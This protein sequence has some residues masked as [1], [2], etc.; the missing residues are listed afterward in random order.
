L[1]TKTVAIY[2][3]T[4][5]S[6]YTLPGIAMKG[7]QGYNSAFIVYIKSY[8]HFVGG[9]QIDVGYR[10]YVII[11]NNGSKETYGSMRTLSR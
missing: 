8:T 4:P 3:K 5:A 6:F 7:K 2:L 11:N 9:G 1:S 10:L